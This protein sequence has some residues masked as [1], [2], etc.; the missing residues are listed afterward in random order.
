MSETTPEPGQITLS[1]LQHLNAKQAKNAVGDTPIIPVA[2]LLIGGYLAWFGQHYFRDQKTVWPSQPVKDILQGEGIP[3][4]VP[5]QSVSKDLEEAAQQSA[6][7]AAGAIASTA[8]AVGT[9]DGDAIAQDAEQ[10]VGKVRYV[11]GGADPSTG[12]DC[13]GMVNYVLCHDLDLDI[14]GTRG[15]D[16]SGSTHG[17]NVASWIATPSLWKKIA[18]GASSSIE[19]GDL[20]LWGPNAHCALMTSSTN[21]VCAA[22][23]AQGTIADTLADQMSGFAQPPL[24]VRLNAVV[25]QTGGDA[26]ANQNIGKLLAGKYGWSS[27]TQWSDL[28]QLWTRESNWSVTAT[29]P[30]SGA[31]GIPQ[32]LPG[33][34]MAADGANWRTSAQT[35]I[36]WGLNYIKTTYGSPS[37]AWAH[38][39]ASGWY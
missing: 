17:P 31:Y 4:H 39:Q 20:V 8:P 19:P 10:Y 34:K 36:K 25:Q 24:I 22:D 37:A 14:P 5:E 13:S 11:W 2:L 23:P 30:N 28:V 15:G 33:D 18:T 32:A 12:W 6:Q 7:A 21:L 16:F 3:A 29:N 1:D 35:Q 27:G 38:E 26:S 9:T